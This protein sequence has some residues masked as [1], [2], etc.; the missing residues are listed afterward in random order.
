MSLTFSTYQTE[1]A[2][3]AVASTNGVI[4]PDFLA[5][6][7]GV[8]DYAEQRIYRE[9]DLLSTVFRDS[10][11]NA[12]A[13]SRNFTLPSA[14]ARFVVVEQINVITPAGA[15]V[16]NGTRNLVISVS[17]EVIDFAWP[18]E[19]AGSP[20]TVPS[21]F[22][23]MTDQT[24]IFGPPPGS[25]FAVEVVG[26]I[27]PAPLSA[28]NTTTFLSQ[29][30]PDL[31]IAASMIFV[32]GW[33]KN[34]GQQADDPRQAISWEDQYSKLFASANVEEMRKKFAGASWTSKAAMPAAVPQ[35]G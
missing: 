6:L 15:T 9:L 11:T 28:T 1:L 12:T 4:D 24:V 16:N 25:S 5:I 2:S 19:A 21:K 17:K 18:S 31:F 13:N 22:A 7:P 34:F 14:T 3:L 32:S 20:T 33:Q 29:F 8:I 23:V 35:R 26:T 10:S 30:L 27:R